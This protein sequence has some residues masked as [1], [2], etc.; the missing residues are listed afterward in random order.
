MVKL[1]FQRK[2]SNSEKKGKTGSKHDESDPIKH[3][4]LV[5]VQW[6]KKNREI[7][8][9]MKTMNRK[10]ESDMVYNGLS[11]LIANPD[12]RLNSK[13]IKMIILYQLDDDHDVSNDI[14][15]TG[16]APT[17]LDHYLNSDQSKRINFSQEQI[18]EIVNKVKLT[19][20]V[21]N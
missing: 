15:I 10:S 6:S 20:R 4:F 2:K 17:R 21:L 13:N 11:D 12:M 16:I 7:K 1:F 3:I 5:Y 14:N 18:D 9:Y 8:T 19:H